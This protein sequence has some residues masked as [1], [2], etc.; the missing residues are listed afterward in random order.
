MDRRLE[1]LRMSIYR[2]YNRFYKTHMISMLL[3]LLLFQ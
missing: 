2:I 3:E 1:R